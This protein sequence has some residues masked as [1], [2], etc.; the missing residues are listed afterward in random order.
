MSELMIARN[1]KRDLR[2]QLLTTVSALALLA[3]VYGSNE[4]KATDQDADRPT[5]W[6]ELG[7]ELEHVSGQGDSFAP[8]FLEANPNSP[9]LRPVSPLQAQNP[10]P[11]SFAE[12][13]KISFQPKDSDWVFSVAVN[14]GRSSN[15]KHVDHQTNGTH[16]ELYNGVPTGNIFT[17]ANFADTHAGHWESHAIL[18]FSAGKDVGLGIFGSDGVSVL[19]LGV[20]FAQFA[21]ET[22][23]DVRARPDLEVK[24][25]TFGARKEPLLHF[26]NYHATG[27][28]SR[29]FHGIGPS[30]SWN[31]SAPFAG[32][33][34]GGEVTFDWGANAALLFGR[35]RARVQHQETAQYRGPLYGITRPSNPY[36]AVYQ[37]SGGHN[38]VR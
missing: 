26:H 36:T 17:Q 4:A 12:D 15:S 30:L 34:Q 28:A 7:G 38:G 33:P 37:H 22:T 21:S 27:D 6:I 29:S 8:G 35:Q 10:I 31:G 20:R 5:V 13:G 9:V 16:V 3:T 19:S 11:F 32:S 23:F 18:D 24:Y 25:A 1:G 2:W 14:Y